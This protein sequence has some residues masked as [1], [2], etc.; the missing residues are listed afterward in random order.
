LSRAIQRLEGQLGGA[1]FDRLPDGVSLTA[2]GALFVKRGRP[3]LTGAREL[4]AE[5]A[6]TLGLETGEL[7][8]LAGPFIADVL[9]GPALGRLL[10]TAPGLVVT[11]DEAQLDRHIEIVMAGEVDVALG[12]MMSFPDHSTLEMEPLRVRSGEYACRA[13]HPLLE[14]EEVG[15]AEI[16]TFPLATNQ[17]G[18]SSW[19]RFIR[20]T[21]MEGRHDELVASA[22]AVRCQSLTA[23]ADM[24]AA[25]DAIGIF[26]R[27][28]IQHRLDNGTMAILPF[29]GPRPTS[30]WGIIRRKGRTPSPAA[31]AFIEAVR[32]ADAHVP[33]D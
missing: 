32:W 8:V 31:K 1:L 33:L 4:E 23:L 7:N 11:V 26:G 29:A 25:S 15:F 14:R 24:V 6:A 18:V 22:S 30:D 5:V 27:G 19:K 20:G 17:L 3:L 10:Q 21:P 2:L 28:M 12:E 13:G 16:M 9:V